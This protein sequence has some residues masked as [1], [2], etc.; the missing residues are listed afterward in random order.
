[1]YLPSGI[2]VIWPEA[3]TGTPTHVV[4]LPSL[5]VTLISQA[6]A[7]SVRLTAISALSPLGRVFSS[8][9]FSYQ[10]FALVG[11]RYRV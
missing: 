1:M 9:R 4:L 10:A 11:E 2:S 7:F 5:S 3:L 6:S 8:S